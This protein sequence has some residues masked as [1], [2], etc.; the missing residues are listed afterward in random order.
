MEN[1]ASNFWKVGQPMTF[2]AAYSDG[3]DSKHLETVAELLQQSLRHFKNR[4][5]CTL[6][7]ACRSCT[8]KFRAT[9]THAL[10]YFTNPQ[11]RR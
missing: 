11:G 6:K 1:A 3:V 10:G 7:T 2:N 8:I 4:V 9:R 5:R